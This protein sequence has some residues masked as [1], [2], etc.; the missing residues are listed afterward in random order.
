MNAPLAVPSTEDKMKSVKA[1]LDNAPAGPARDAA[2]R[3]Y[4]AAERAQKANHEGEY[5]RKLDNAT[6]ALA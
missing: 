4:A 5:N 3:H 1:A 6:H 2:L